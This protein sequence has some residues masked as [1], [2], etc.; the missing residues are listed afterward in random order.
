[1]QNPPLL[2]V[3]GTRRQHVRAH[4]SPPHGIDLREHNRD[5]RNRQTRMSPPA[6]AATPRPR[7]APVRPAICGLPCRSGRVWCSV[8]VPEFCRAARLAFLHPGTRNKDLLRGS[9]EILRTA[10]CNVLLVIETWLSSCRML[11]RLDLT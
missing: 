10:G 6:H 5:A 2:T 4:F 11:T 1:M 7:R 3:T 8:T 9:S